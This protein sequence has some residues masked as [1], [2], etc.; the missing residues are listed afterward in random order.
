MLAPKPMSRLLIVA[1]RDQAVPIV[2]GVYRENLFHI[3]DYVEQG[4]EGYEG[5]KIGT[6]LLG[7]TEA[8]TSLSRSGQ[9]RM[10]LQSVARMSTRNRN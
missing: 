1:S 3:E 4:R 9:S 7:A 6:P 10:S 5:F 8:S 2:R